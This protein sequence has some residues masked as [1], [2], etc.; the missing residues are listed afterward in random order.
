MT[1]VPTL[2][3]SRLTLRAPTLDDF[4]A[5]AGIYAAPRSR[6]TGGPL[7]RDKAWTSFAADFFGWMVQGFGYWTVTRRSDDQVCGMVGLSQ[8]PAY[9][10]LELGWMLCQPAEGH[11]FAFEAAKA[12]RD[13]A[14]QKLPITTLVSYIDPD[15]TRSIT[16]ARRL[17]CT[18]DADAAR[19]DP[20][21]LVFRHPCPG[22]HGVT[23]GGHS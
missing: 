18:L 19:E 9:P 7:N 14:F 8:P 1:L 11:G 22:E 3:T 4:S 10:E 16:L 21:D 12:C 20:R 6:H 23:K 17:G 2:T 13:W 15:N 5:Y